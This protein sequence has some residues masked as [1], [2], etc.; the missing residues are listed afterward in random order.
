MTV[1]HC[2]VV[3]DSD[4][5]RKVERPMLAVLQFRTSEAAD[6]DA[7]LMQCGLAMPDAIL[8]NWRMPNVSGIECLQRLRRMAGGKAPIVLY[9]LTENDAA[10]IA[11]AL[12]AGA[13][14]VLIK[15]F[16]RAALRQ[17]LVAVGL[18]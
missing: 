1:K 9:C 18:L 15:P 6:V 12:E 2:L 5:V 14:E 17:K 16:D 7:A 4:I 3:D 13:D 8:L 10:E 11:R